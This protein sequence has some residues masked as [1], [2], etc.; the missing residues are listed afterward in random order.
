MSYI[1]ITKQEL[2]EHIKKWGKEPK[3]Y[4]MLEGRTLQEKKLIIKEYLETAEVS[5]KEYNRLKQEIQEPQTPPRPTREE[6]L[7][8]IKEYLR[9]EELISDAEYTQLK[10]ELEPP[11]DTTPILDEEEELSDTEETHTD[12]EEDVKSDTEGD[13]TE[14]NNDNGEYCNNN[15]IEETNIFKINTTFK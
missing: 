12:T 8:I 10:Q 4:K 6:Q 7:H 13:I 9:N 1:F 11:K 2:K 3:H 5:E 15:H 14:D